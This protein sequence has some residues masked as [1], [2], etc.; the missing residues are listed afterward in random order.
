MICLSEEQVRGLLRL[1]D[2]IPAMEK[3]LIDFSAGRIRQPVRSIV[4]VPEHGGLWGLMPAVCGDV[5]GIK[6][7]TVYEGNASR[8]L[9]THQATIELF[10]SDTGEPLATMDGRLITELRTAA[11]TAVATRLLAK[12]DARILAILG[13]GVQARAHARA[14]RLVRPFE[15]TRLWSR[16]PEHAARCAEEIG[17]KAM[18]AEEAVRGADVVV[19]VTYAAEPILEGAWLSPGTLVNAVGAI[20]PGKRELDDHAMNATI[21]VDSRAAAAQEAGDIIHS[22]AS[23][24]AEIGELLAGVRP[25]PPRGGR[26]VF[27]SLGLA[28]EDVAAA[29]L[30][31][32]RY[33]GGQGQTE[34]FS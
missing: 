30:V 11:V 13:S 29:R 14:L 32:D 18:G 17:A 9:P 10:R 4:A 7:V 25:L 6:L 19:T 22:G 24:H 12:P 34:R 5:M 8:G 21:V 31:W 28:V 23:I 3:A 33:Q 2:L 27:K 20:G 1:E 16:T 26:V 15:E